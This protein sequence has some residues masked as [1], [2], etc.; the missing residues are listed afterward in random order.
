MN[1]SNRLLDLYRQ[2]LSLRTNQ[3]VADKLGVKQPTVSMWLN[4]KSHPNAAAIEAMCNA[5]NE[6]VA[7]WLPLIEADRCRT[8]EDRKAWLRLAQVAASII[9]VY[10]AIRFGANAHE[11]MAFAPFACIHYAKLR[12]APMRFREPP[13]DVLWLVLWAVLAVACVVCHVAGSGW[14]VRR[15]SASCVTGAC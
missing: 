12:T 13:P 6:P 10:T 8:A 15:A 4:E 11:M 1:N 2:K 14:S 3:A 9:A 5:T 7:K